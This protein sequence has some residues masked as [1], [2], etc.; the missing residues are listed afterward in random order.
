MGIS[1]VHNVTATYV[2]DWDSDPWSDSNNFL[3]ALW[4]TQH[5]IY[6]PLK[7]N[8]SIE[9]C[10]ILWIIL[11]HIHVGLFLPLSP[12]PQKLS[13]HGHFFKILLRLVSQ[14]VYC[15][16]KSTFPFCL[17]H[18]YGTV[19]VSLSCDFKRIKRVKT[20]ELSYVR[21]VRHFLSIEHQY[22]GSM[23]SLTLLIQS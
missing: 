5:Y 13:V 3:V 16:Q 14:T 7:Q 12:C 18:V 6:F 4:K 22:S 2:T 15:I 11:I 17:V 23:D 21:Y 9:W 1:T 10:K 20:N 8:L 19:E